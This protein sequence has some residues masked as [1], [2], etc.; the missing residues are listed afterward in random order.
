MITAPHPDTDDGWTV[1][2]AGVDPAREASIEARLALANGV[3]G[4][5]AA[6]AAS[7]GPSWISRLGYQRWSSWPRCL[8]AGLF[9]TPDT[10]P[11]VPALQP[12]P[13]WSRLRI[14]LDGL[15]LWLATGDL[16]DHRRRLDLRRAV[17]TGEWRHLHPSGAVATLRHT[18]ALS[19]ADRA[20]ALQ[21]LAFSLDRDGIAVRLTAPLDIAGLDLVIDT[22]APDA[23]GW[24]TATPGHRAAIAG[25][26][27]LLRAGVEVAPA[28][29]PP[30]QW[31]WCW[32]SIAGETIE[33]ERIAGVA[34]VEGARPD[35]LPVARAARDRAARLGWRASLAA[36]EA[37]WARRW[38]DSAIDLAGDAALA[39]GLR[40]AIYHMCAVA[41]PDDPAVSIGARALS[42]DGYLG[43][44]FWDT[45]TYLLPF[46]IATWPEAA[47]ALLTSRHR[48]LPAA[49]AKAIAIGCRGA[50]FAWESADTG[51]ETTPD[52]VIG[53]DGSMVDVLTGRFEQHISADI[54]HAVWMYWRAS[55]DSRFLREAGAELLLEIARFW[56]SR[57]QPESDGR[58]HIRH[59]IGPDEYHEDVDDNAFTNVMAR[60]SIARG[61]EVL[62]LLRR[63]WLD[64]AERLT[65]ALGLTEAELADWR[66]AASRIATGLDPAT[67]LY[68][69]F[70]GFHA[71]KPLDLA[72][73]PQRT[74][75]IDVLVGRERVA[76][77]QVAKQADVV[78][79]AALLPEEFPGAALA[80]NY[81]HYADRCAHGSSL[82]H[83]MHALVAARL[84]LAEEALTHLRATIA[85]D[86]GP[87]SD[88]SAGIHIAGLGGLWQAVLLGFAGLDLMGDTLALDP[89]LPAGWSAL[90]FTVHWQGRRIGCRMSGTECALTLLEGEPVGV[91]VAGEVLVLKEEGSASF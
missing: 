61:L 67:G 18:R 69:Q 71:L 89:R 31:T 91:R 12:V 75:P 60:W 44:V 50:L 38:Q 77:S 7:R 56:A 4:E 8:V 46:Y 19:L 37:A 23:I 10:L 47:R 86:L 36:H 78:M 34:R 24:R 53:P 29:A 17:L 72:A 68:E 62:A 80:L 41:N 13:D 90:A 88:S 22:L 82:S 40:F 27:R 65:A 3:L 9:D 52:Q 45:E 39:E 32:R 42:G 26:A 43:H 14:T 87:E 25:A 16:L 81:R 33:F 35:P 66:D 83:A 5:R 51:R 49:R 2:V 85:A 84:G 70:A 28:P 48:T 54:A 73:Y 74:V 6:R 64:D 1:E 63:D 57:A 76:A 30:L 55:G 79:L 11:A 20:V 21:H 15:P 58:R 59:V